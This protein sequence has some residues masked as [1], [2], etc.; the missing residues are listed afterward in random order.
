[1]LDTLRKPLFLVSLILIAIAV[2]IEAVTRLGFGM[3]GTAILDSLLL[4]T[5][6]LIALPLVLREDV[7]GRIQGLMTAVV[8]VVA[9]ILSFLLAFAAFTALMEMLGLI[10][11]TP[12]GTVIYLALFGHFHRD[13]ANK[14]FGLALL[15]K[16]FF[17]GFL[18][19]SE[20]GFLR[21]KKLIVLVATVLIANVVV[22]FLHGLVPGVLVSITDAIAGIVVGIVALLWS[23]WFVLD[24][25]PGIVN[26]LGL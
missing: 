19:A 5:I 3:R 22:T 20:Q 26:A 18:V 8:G 6:A 13:S 21:N 2:L 16:M 25:I 4:F 17:A 9:V 11:A 12:F 14:V 1:M 7:H 24:A 23:I 15:L 10:V